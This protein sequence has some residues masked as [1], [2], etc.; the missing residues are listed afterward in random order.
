MEDDD[1]IPPRP[2]WAKVGRWLFA[3]V[4]LGGVLYLSGVYQ[5][6]FL[7]RTPAG[8]EQP[9]LE[10][11]V[12]AEQLT[13]PVVVHILQGDPGSERTG[14]DAVRLVENANRIWAQGNISFF[15]QNVTYH[16]T[17]VEDLRAFDREPQAFITSSDT[18]DPAVA[19]LYLTRTLSGVNGLAYGGTSAVSVADFTSTL[20]YRTLAHEFG[21]LL[22]LEH[23]NSSQRLMSTGATG[24]DLSLEEIATARQAAVVYTH[25][26]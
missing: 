13:V 25:G 26:Q 21:H 12:N 19:N 4:A 18:Y 14:D 11:K 20:D 7:H 5:Y 22:G 3:L 8:A 9:V 6:L 24:V 16:D 15:I 17:P 2:W 1:S 23:V 10:T